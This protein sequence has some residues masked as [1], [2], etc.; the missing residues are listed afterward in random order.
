MAGGDY[1][2]GR[3]Q[4]KLRILKQSFFDLCRCAVEFAELLRVKREGMVGWNVSLD[5]VRYGLL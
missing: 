1:E 2:S 4:S 5:E 3:Y